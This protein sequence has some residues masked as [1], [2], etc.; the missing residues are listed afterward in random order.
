MLA[1]AAACLATLLVACSGSFMQ[2]RECQFS[3]CYTIRKGATPQEFFGKRASVYPPEATY[4]IDGDTWEVW[5]FTVGTLEPGNIP[6]PEDATAGGVSV[7][8]DHQEY[9]AFKNDRLDDWGWGTLPRVVKQ[10]RKRM[11]QLKR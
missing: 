10:N 2:L 3:D 6:S 1:V 11:T 5:V 7:S 9:V 4:Q 8:Q